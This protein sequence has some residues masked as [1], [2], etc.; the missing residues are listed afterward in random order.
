[1]SASDSESSNEGEQIRVSL[2]LAAS[3]KDRTLEVPTE[4]IA[5]PADIGRKGL[6]AVVNHLLGRPIPGEDDD[7]SDNASNTS[8]ES[9]KLPQ[10]NLEFILGKSMLCRKI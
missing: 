5:V 8:S 1:M 9:D 10:L 3:V 4:P 6:S 2:R 7:D